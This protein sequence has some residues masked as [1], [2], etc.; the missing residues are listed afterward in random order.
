MNKPAAIIVSFVLDR[1]PQ[2]PVSQRIELTRALASVE[3][4]EARS[5]ELLSIAS[6]L[7][8]IERRQRKLTLRFKGGRNA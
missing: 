1:L 5:K 6:G 8:R 7:E 3:P 4:D 2:V